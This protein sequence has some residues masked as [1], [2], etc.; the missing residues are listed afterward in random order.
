MEISTLMVMILNCLIC[1]RLLLLLLVEKENQRMIRRWNYCCFCLV[2]QVRV[3]S[4]S[5]TTLLVSN[6]KWGQSIWGYCQFGTRVIFN[7]STHVYNII[8]GFAWK[9]K[10][11]VKY[12]FSFV[13]SS[14]DR[15]ATKL[16]F[17][18]DM[19]MSHIEAIGTSTKLFIEKTGV[20]DLFFK[21]V[22]DKQRDI[23]VASQPN[24]SDERPLH[25]KK[26][27]K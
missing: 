13:D 2:N 25:K 10:S 14:Y 24:C 16:V 21:N 19:F 27:K 9:F 8:V 23:G 12:P 3:S 1:L 6:K 17:G 4:K 26:E 7:L 18:D 5:V 15:K 22:Q 20:V 11:K